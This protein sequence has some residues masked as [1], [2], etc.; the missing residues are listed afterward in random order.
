M[1]FKIE[2]PQISDVQRIWSQSIGIFPPQIL[3]FMIEVIGHPW[4]VY[5]LKYLAMKYKFWKMQIFD[6]G[7]QIFMMLT[8]NDIYM[9]HLDGIVKILQ[10]FTTTLVGELS[11]AKYFN[12]CDDK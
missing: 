10:D 12:A 11:A 4:V 1:K 6:T 2:L 9:L 3:F 7:N 5:V 8:T